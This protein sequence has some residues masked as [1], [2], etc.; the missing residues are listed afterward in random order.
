MKKYASNES[1]PLTL[2]LNNGQVECQIC[3]HRCR[4]RVG[5]VGLCGVRIGGGA[6]SIIPIATQAFVARGKGE[7]EDHP[8]FHFYPGMKT[9]GIGA[10][11]CTAACKYCQNWELALAPRISK[12]WH[13]EPAFSSQN[14]IIEIAKKQGCGALAFTYNEPTVWIE[15]LL[16]LASQAQTAGL[17]VILVTNGYIT[18]TTLRLLT[19]YIDAIKLDLK[20]AND[21]F[22][23]NIVAIPIK[24]VIATLEALHR[25]TIWYEISTVIVPGQNDDPLAIEQ[26]IALLLRVAGPEVP[27][28]LMRF[29]PA[30]QMSNTFPGTLAKLTQIRQQALEAGLK[31][32]YI[33]NVPNL[34]ERQTTCPTCQTILSHRQLDDLQPLPKQCPVCNTLIAGR[35]L[36]ESQRKKYP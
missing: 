2:V 34:T 3:P 8:L 30:Y 12:S 11:G 36:N 33:S 24:P 1:N 13:T 15:A 19:P 4:L 21:T 22:Y 27:W 17:R 35:G 16:D 10:I 20:G 23:R 28:H 14:K 9:L 29:F 7:V 18:E 26:M 31:Y 25:S 5:Q 32:V 6:N